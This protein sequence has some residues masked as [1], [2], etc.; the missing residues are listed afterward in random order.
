[1]SGCSESGQWPGC[2]SSRAQALGPGPRVIG[3]LI[4]AGPAS[5]SAGWEACCS[6]R[7]T[8]T[9]SGMPLGGKAPA[10]EALVTLGRGW[11]LRG[12]WELCLGLRFCGCWWRHRMPGRETKEEQLGAGPRA[13]AY[14]GYR[15][16]TGLR[17]SRGMQGL[18]SEAVPDISPGHCGGPGVVHA[19]TRCLT[20]R[21]HGPCSPRT[22]VF[23]LSV[24]GPRF[25]VCPHGGQSLPVLA[26]PA[27]QPTPPF[28]PTPEQ[29]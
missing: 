26:G 27:C 5:P 20:Q 11:R 28:A 6:P 25:V 10:H 17:C 13:Q 21:S 22:C 23:L 24:L 3:V 15:R 2:L 18:S 16:G 29:L 12:R 9:R 19:G 4:A 7:V 8:G 1:M 14:R